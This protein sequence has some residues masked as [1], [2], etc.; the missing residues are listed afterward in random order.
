MLDPKDL[1]KQVARLSGLDF[2]PTTPEGWTELVK[3][4]QKRCLT[5]DHVARVLDRWIETEERVPKPSQL[6]SLCSDVPADAAADHPILAEPCDECGPEGL[7]R[8]V[9]R[10]NFDGQP[11]DCQARCT[12]PR[13][14]QLA[15]LDAKRAHDAA[16]RERKQ[17]KRLTRVDGGR[18]KETG[19]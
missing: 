8:W 13:G 7:W 19:S 9:E 2:Q 12:C 15:A 3:V 6:G 4:L 5:M 16:A 17:P 11:V 18:L 1:K 10:L 14:R